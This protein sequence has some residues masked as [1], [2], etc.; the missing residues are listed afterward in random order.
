MEIAAVLTGDLIGS[1]KVA[2][3]EI[4]KAMEALADTATLIEKWTSTET[5]FARFRG[6]GWQIYLA[7]PRKILRAS[8][9]GL[10]KLRSSGSG[11]A[12]RLSIGVGLVDRLGK[13]GL[14]DAA[15][16]A[17]TTSGRNLDHAHPIFNNFVYADLGPNERWKNAAMN[18]S[19]WQASRWTPEQAE[20]VAL[21]LALPRPSD[22]ILAKGLGITRQALQARLKG[23]GLM[24]MSAALLAFEIESEDS[25]EPG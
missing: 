1:T 23:S 17:F 6:D 8:V 11:L 2:L 10:A 16:W 24:A 25:G 4:D 14:A 7:D 15:G 9:L 3:D 20:A 18:L 22:E 5:R 19:V 12:T 13:S 21:A